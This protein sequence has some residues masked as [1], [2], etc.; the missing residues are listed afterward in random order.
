MRPES[1]ITL[2]ALI[3]ACTSTHHA[4]ACSQPSFYGSEPNA[5]SAYEKPS[6]PYCFR[7]RSCD[8]W[9]VRNYIS[10]VEDYVSNLKRYVNDA[11]TFSNEA[12]SFADEVI[13]YAKCEANEVNTQHR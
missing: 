2:V 10:D 9:Q 7:D 8:E 5:P 4:S 11:V 12:R 3:F 13:S 1:S 6:V